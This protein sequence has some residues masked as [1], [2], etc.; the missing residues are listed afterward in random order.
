VID[1]VFHVLFYA[2]VAAASPL[3][4]T[5]TFLVV[6]GER[7]R[8]N[9][10]AF[11]IGFVAGTAIACIL[12][13]IVGEAAVEKLD[14]HETIEDLLTLA[15]GVALLG[16][17]LRAR[18]REPAPAAEGS[19]RTA[20][21]MASLRHVHPAAACSMAGLLGFGGP[22]RLLLTL[23]AMASVNGAHQGHVANL[24][25]AL[26]YIAVA[27]VLVWVPVGMVVIAG[28]RAAVLLGQG[29]SWMTEHARELRVWLCLAFGAALVLDGILSPFL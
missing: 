11:L 6:R 21:I 24:T 17:G 4:L 15:L 20:A 22:K 9:G 16:F 1:A 14:S 19:S 18:G 5:A 8:T 23:L 3:V 10:I 7:P 25:L 29:E 13:L 27:T 28:E 12:G 2:I 26:L